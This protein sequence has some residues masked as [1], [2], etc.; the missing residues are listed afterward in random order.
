MA[1][2]MMSELPDDAPT[3]FARPGMLSWTMAPKVP[4]SVPRVILQTSNAPRSIH[5]TKP[6]AKRLSETVPE[7]HVIPA[8]DLIYQL[9]WSWVDDPRWQEQLRAFVVALIAIKR[10]PSSPGGSLQRLLPR[11]LE[12]IFERL[13][14]RELEYPLRRKVVRQALQP[15]VDEALRVA[16]AEQAAGR[17][18]Y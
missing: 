14:Y 11:M 9:T 17:P 6:N 13:P 5:M 10:P 8:P 1:L 15:F 16:A 3:P 2:R 12:Q 4:V 7:P 18:R